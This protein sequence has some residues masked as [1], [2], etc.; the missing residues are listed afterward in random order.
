MYVCCLLIGHLAEA[1]G[2]DQPRQRRQVSGL[3][4][5]GGQQCVTH[6]D[7]AAHDGGELLPLFD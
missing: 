7:V 1:G 3:A 2:Q 4:Q 6:D 5:V